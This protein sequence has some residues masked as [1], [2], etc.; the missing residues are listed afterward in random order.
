T[1]SGSLSFGELRNTEVTP[2]STGNF[3]MTYASEGG[4]AYYRLLSATGTT[5]GTERTIKSGNVYGAY[6]AELSNGNILLV[7]GGGGDKVSG[8][9]IINQT[10]ATVVADTDLKNSAN[11]YFSIKGAVAFSGGNWAITYSHNNNDHYIGFYSNSGALVNT[12]S[13]GSGYYTTVL[14]PLSN[15]NMFLLI[16]K[17]SISTG[18]HS[19]EGTVFTNNGTVHRSDLGITSSSV[20]GATVQEKSNGTFDVLYRSNLN[21][22]TEVARYWNSGEFIGIANTHQ[23]AG[24]IYGAAAISGTEY[25]YYYREG[26]DKMDFW[27]PG[28]MSSTESKSV[29]PVWEFGRG[30]ISS[31]GG[32]QI[33]IYEDPANDDR[34]IYK[35]MNLGYLLE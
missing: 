3:I 16:L 2:L 8:F 34:Y 11:T 5:L 15:G 19:L 20:S 21:N 24:H 18:N 1:L 10:G 6:A 23:A 14:R 26:N 13:I 7:W 9:K 35:L 31:M 12:N 29:T 22:R 28:K 27:V 4:T 33:I 32:V 25:V 30:S 17:M